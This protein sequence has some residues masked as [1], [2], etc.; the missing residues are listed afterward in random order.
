[1]GLILERTDVITFTRRSEMHS[2]QQAE[3]SVAVAA[4][5]AENP[6]VGDA[7]GLNWIMRGVVTKCKKSDLS[8]GTFWERERGRRRGLE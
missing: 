6:E 3:P 1:M 8:E 2:R 4:G 5:T 7:V